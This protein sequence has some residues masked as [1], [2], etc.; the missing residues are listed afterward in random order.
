MQ[1]I[2]LNLHSHLVFILSAHISLFAIKIFLFSADVLVFSSNLLHFSPYF[3]IFPQIFR[4][5]DFN[6]LSYLLCMNFKSLI[7][8]GMEMKTAL[9]VD[10]YSIRM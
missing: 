1:C 10:K 5:S 4:F 7:I 6:I 2:T 3:G 8:D 9:N